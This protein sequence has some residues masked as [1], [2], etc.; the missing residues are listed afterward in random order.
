MKC[1]GSNMKYMVGNP[2]G[3]QQDIIYKYIT[4][5]S[6]LINPYCLDTK[7]GRI[8]D[9]MIPNSTKTPVKLIRFLLFFLLLNWIVDR[10]M[11]HGRFN[12]S[13]V[14]I[15]VD[16]TSIWFVGGSYGTRKKMGNKTFCP[17]P[18]ETFL[19]CRIINFDWPHFCK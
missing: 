6:A 4:V 19:S 18:Q 5:N 15:S 7:V 12:S 17:I 11:W 3:K 10:E 16:V 8:N 9:T 14:S 1:F 13:K 2:T